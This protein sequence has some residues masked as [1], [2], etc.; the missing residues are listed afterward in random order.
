MPMLVILMQLVIENRAFLTLL[1]GVI[2]RNLIVI[3][4]G[5]REAIC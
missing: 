3:E 1:M 5:C 2:A 4:N